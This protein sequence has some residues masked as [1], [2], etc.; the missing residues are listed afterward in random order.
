MGFDNGDLAV[1]VPMFILAILCIPVL[2]IDPCK[3]HNVRL[4][5]YEKLKALKKK[6]DEEKERISK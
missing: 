3:S 2:F 4:E 6:Q 5:N 1:L